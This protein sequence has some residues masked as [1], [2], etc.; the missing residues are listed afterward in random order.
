MENI[1]YG[2]GQ[3][4]PLWILI[5]VCLNFDKPLPNKDMFSLA[6]HPAWHVLPKILLPFSDQTIYIFCLLS[7]T[8][9]KVP[10]LSLFVLFE[11]YKGLM[12]VI[13]LLPQRI[14]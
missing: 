13:V 1:L 8:L 3:D 9:F 14:K 10:S 11:R 4:G 12:V 2:S 6:D 7:N 5:I